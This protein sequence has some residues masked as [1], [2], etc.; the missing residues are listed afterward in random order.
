MYLG[1]EFGQRGDLF[2]LDDV[3]IKPTRGW[4]GLSR[5]FQNGHIVVNQD[6][7]ASNVFVVPANLRVLE[8]VDASEY[9]S[10]LD[11]NADSLVTGNVLEV[12]AENGYMLIY[13]P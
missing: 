5:S 11:H 1:K 12:E 2:Y 7:D 3:L 8:G 9:Y 13:D 4:M 6:P 10:D